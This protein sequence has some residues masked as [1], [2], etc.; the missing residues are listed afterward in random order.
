MSDRVQDNDITL[1]TS[2]IKLGNRVFTLREVPHPILQV[3]KALEKYANSKV[4][5][6]ME[7]TRLALAN[8]TGEDFDKQRKRVEEFLDRRETR[9]TLPSNHG[10]MP[11]VYKSRNGFWVR[12]YPFILSP[13]RVKGSLARLQGCTGGIINTLL[14]S[15]FEDA[16]RDG[17]LESVDEE[18]TV[19]ILDHDIRLPGM[20]GVRD[21]SL[22]LYDVENFHTYQDGRVCTGNM[23]NR[24]LKSLSPQA[25]ADFLNTVNTFSMSRSSLLY[26]VNGATVQEV[27]LSGLFQASRGITIHKEVVW[28]NRER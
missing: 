10:D 16:V 18:N 25:V 15:A 26:K 11:V 14:Q 20:F 17:R 24:V 6:V 8:D 9:I 22:F 4:K 28:N 5:A 13:M 3:E 27:P 19:A 21:N 7:S 1:N 23:P 2:Y 12:L